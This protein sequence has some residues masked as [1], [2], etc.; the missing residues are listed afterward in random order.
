MRYASI[1]E[2]ENFKITFSSPLSRDTGFDPV[3]RDHGGFYFYTLRRDHRGMILI[4]V[5]IL[6]SV[7]SLLVVLS[8][9]SSALE[10][11]M[12]HNQLKR[13]QTNQVM[14]ACFIAAR[15]NLPC[16]KSPYCENE[17]HHFV[18]QY[19]T[20]LLQSDEKEKINYWRIVCYVRPEE[21][22]GSLEEKH[23]TIAVLQKDR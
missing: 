14:E 3:S 7:I 4:T 2:R 19:S 21:K 22:Y 16:V 10:Q 13:V 9:E 17:F 18:Y 15:Q 23:I 12:S 8:L 6:L 11:R 5:L 20:Q 1:V